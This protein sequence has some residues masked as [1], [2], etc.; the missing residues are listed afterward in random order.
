MSFGRSDTCRST[1]EVEMLW[2]V[3][4][5]LFVCGEATP[6]EGRRHQAAPAALTELR[7]ETFKTTATES[8]YWSR[9]GVALVE[10]SVRQEENTRRRLGAF[11]AAS[12]DI[13]VAVNAWLSDPTAAEAVYGH[14]SEWTTKGMWLFF[15]LHV[16]PR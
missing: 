13:Y 8:D 5:A 2:S 6:V 10:A 4:L 12:D 9:R 11:D 14:I 16:C 7:G 15:F 3:A 1:V